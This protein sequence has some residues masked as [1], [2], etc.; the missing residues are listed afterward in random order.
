VR[1]HFFPA[2]TISCL[3]LR[4]ETDI[5]HAQVHILP[6][7]AEVKDQFKVRCLNIGISS[8]PQRTRKY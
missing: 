6:D 1:A 5:G 4:V 8:T 3:I 7:R 2:R